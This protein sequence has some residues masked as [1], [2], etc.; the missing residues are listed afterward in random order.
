MDYGQTGVKQ[1]SLSPDLLFEQGLTAGV[2]TAPEDVNPDYANSLSS[3][4]QEEKIQIQDRDHQPLGNIAAAATAAATAALSRNPTGNLG[5][6]R[7]GDISDPDHLAEGPSVPQRHFIEDI[8]GANHKTDYETDHKTEA[9]TETET[10]IEAKLATPQSEFDPRPKNEPQISVVS[11]EPDSP[12]A[13]QTT[14]RDIEANRHEIQH[15]GQ[16]TLEGANLIEAEMRNITDPS[17]IVGIRD[18]WIDAT[19]GGNQ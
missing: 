7:I 14:L 12:L 4:G 5:E 11:S 13:P 2:G 8:L 16:L 17:V 10:K 1:G 19:K 9:K 3:W 18:A 6:T 15:N